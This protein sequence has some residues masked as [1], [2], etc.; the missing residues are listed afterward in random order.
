MY[1]GNIV[2]SGSVETILSNPQHPY[3]KAL[4]NCI[5]RLGDRRERLTTIG[6]SLDT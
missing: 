6:D 5:P 1:Q 4:I 3:T 2:E